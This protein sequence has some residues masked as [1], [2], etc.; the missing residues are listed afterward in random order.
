MFPF[1]I[2]IRQDL[3]RLIIKA[4]REEHNEKEMYQKM[5][6]QAKK[7]ELKN[8]QTQKQQSVENSKVN[9]YPKYS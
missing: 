8:K 5:L 1:I 6:G 9:C 2:N 4:R 7:L 3:A